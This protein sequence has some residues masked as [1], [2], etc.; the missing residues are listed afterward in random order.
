MISCCSQ[1]K[2]AARGASPSHGRPASALTQRSLMTR[3]TQA[4][5]LVLGSVLIILAS[6]ALTVPNETNLWLLTIAV[7]VAAIYLGVVQWLEH[8]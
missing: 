5:C 2:S 8:H 4:E 1:W 7:V 6:M 3:R